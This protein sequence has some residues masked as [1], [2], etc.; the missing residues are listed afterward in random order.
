MIVDTLTLQIE[1]LEIEERYLTRFQR[2][3]S[4]QAFKYVFCPDV[5]KDG[6]LPRIT[7]KKK[8]SQFRAG[9]YTENVDI[10]FSAPKIVY[11]TNY[12]GVD[13]NDYNGVVEGLFE[14]LKFIFNGYELSRE[15]IQRSNIKTIAFAF[16]FILPKDYAHPVEFLK[17][18]PFFDIGKNYNRFKDTYYT[19]GTE[20]GFCGRIYNKQV[21]WKLYDKGAEIIDNAK[22]TE[23]L[24]TASKIKQGLLPDKVIRLEITYQNRFSLKRHLAT[25]TD[26]NNDRERHLSEVFNNKLCKSIL[27]ESFNKFADV[28]NV[29]ALDMPIYPVDSFLKVAKSCKMPLFDAYAL[30]GKSLATQQ[31]GSLQLKLISDNYYSKQDRA[32]ADKKFKRFILAHSIPSFTLKRFIEECRKQLVE[33][34][35]MKPDNLPT[36]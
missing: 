2:I 24:R 3:R 31:A 33:F 20:I 16:N 28:V 4:S 30:L 34:K 23:E 13:E 1:R 18:I 35:I 17:I 27:L 7:I 21:S 5:V 6:Y 8:E 22:S 36:Q 15:Q 9:F 12:F 32:R 10:E 11:G 14:K 26:H 25:R 19:E 29:Q